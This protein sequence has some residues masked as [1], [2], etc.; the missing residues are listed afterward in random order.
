[1]ELGAIISANPQ[2]LKEIQ[3]LLVELYGLPSRVIDVEFADLP[4]EQRTAKARSRQSAIRSNPVGERVCAHCAS[5][6]SLQRHH[7]IPTRFGGR[8]VR[9]NL[10]WLCRTCHKKEHE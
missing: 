5:S 10:L 2:Q 3:R 4:V 8:N 9:E 6:H 7:L 1:M